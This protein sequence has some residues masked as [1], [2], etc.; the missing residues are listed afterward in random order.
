MQTL[1]RDLLS[2]SR[3]GRADTPFEVMESGQV[4]Q[5]ALKNVST[6]VQE[7]GAE[8]TS[9][10]LPTIKGNPSQLGMVF[11]NLLGNA[12]KFRRNGTP[13]RIRVSAKQNSAHW[14]FS[15]SDNGIGIDP[16]YADRVFRVFQ[17][18]HTRQE[19]SGTGIGLAI[20]KRVVERHGG[21]IWVEPNPEEQG[22][23]F[24]FTIPSDRR[25]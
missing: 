23:R 8:I 24:S 22:T 3:V 16:A 7:S 17:R 14:L 5:T 12:I 13:V 18:L 20:C 25:E 21:R 2:Y 6:A 1:I 4:L 11:Q 9:D 15:V 19:Y 10:P